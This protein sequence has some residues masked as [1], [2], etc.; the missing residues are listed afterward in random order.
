MG[1]QVG[2]VDFEEAW[3]SGQF[4]M[5]DCIWVGLGRFVVW[6][7]AVQNVRKNKGGGSI[8]NNDSVNR[9]RYWLTSHAVTA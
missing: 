1:S 7:V 6:D 4:P 2:N 9:G 3:R 5:K 8:A